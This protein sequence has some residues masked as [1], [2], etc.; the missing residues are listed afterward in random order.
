MSDYFTYVTPYN[1]DLS[2]MKG[3]DL[4][5][6][7]ESVMSLPVTIRRVM[8]G[9]RTAEYIVKELAPA[10]NLS[11]D[12]SEKI[13]RLIRDA[14]LGRLDMQDMP[15]ALIDSCGLLPE[16][17]S[18]LAQKIVDDLFTPIIGE[19]LEVRKENLSLTPSHQLTP[20]PVIPGQQVNPNNIIDLRKSN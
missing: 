12:Q 2:Q 15:Q 9:S 3:A 17:A 20:P 14:L 7:I 13:A 5:S 8:F 18:Q 1:V 11:P 16:V 19:V 6:Y 10:F 4:G